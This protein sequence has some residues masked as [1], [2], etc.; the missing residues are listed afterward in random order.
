MDN[1]VLSYSTLLFAL[2]IAE[3]VLVLNTAALE[4]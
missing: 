4:N 3:S 1:S 2:E